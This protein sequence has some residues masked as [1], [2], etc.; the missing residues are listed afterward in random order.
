MIP[1]RIIA[2]VLV[3]GLSAFGA[4]TEVY[5][6]ERTD[7]LNGL[8]YGPAGPYERFAATAHFA[9]DPKAEA[10]RAIV[11]IDLAPRNAKGLVEFTADVVVFKPRD[12]TK[13]NGT[14]LLDIPN[15]GGITVLRTFGG[16]GG[17][18]FGDRFLLEQGYTV[19]VV[20]WQFDN[21]KGL[22]VYV[23]TARGENGPVRGLI[24]SQFIPPSRTTT[25]P[26]ADRSHT[27]Y[28][29]LDIND[30]AARLTVRNTPAARPSA[31]PR[32]AWKFADNGTATMAAGFEPGK[33]YELVYTA[34]DP[35]ISGLGFA[36]VRDFVSYLRYG[37]GSA[38][39]A[40]SD[41]RRFLKRSVAFGA[42]QSGRFLRTLMYHGFNADEKRRKVLDGVWAHVAGGGRGSF[43]VRFAQPSRDGH[44]LLNLFYPTD[45]FPFAD[46]PET[47]PE[48]GAT[49]GLLDRSLN[50]PAA[51][52]IFYTNGSYEY[53]G[54]AA[55]LTHTTAD[56][57]RDVPLAPDT[58]IYFLSGTQHG[59]GAKP[60]RNANI[61]NRANPV[62]Y[63]W[64][65]RALLTAFNAWITDGTAPPES[66]Y[67][68]I[69][70]NQLVA[71]EATP[72][73]RLPGVTYPASIYHAQRLEFGPE[74]A[75]RGIVSQEPPKMGKPFL[76]LVPRVSLEDGNEI[77]GVRQVDLRVPLATYTGWNL[78]TPAIG[79]PGMLYD[80]IGSFV[81]LAR[82]K[83]ERAKTGDPRPSLEDRYR[84][85]DD[86]MTK[87]A[88]AAADLVRERFLLAKDVP[89]VIAEAAER[90]DLVTQ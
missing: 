46:L 38:V 34:Q 5:V 4:V 69:D 14:I 30:P 15:R 55:S 61:Q 59:A 9:I 56:S 27:A 58:R 73:V 80:M 72:F 88:A 39:S 19:V 23:P 42:S 26:L 29:P 70:R 66:Q 18:E 81:P 63:R 32:R 89:R 76:N 6:Q 65:L 10:N 60:E 57:K 41:Q 35:P 13:G 86:Y 75:T 40:L 44:P 90:W 49:A 2:A 1:M 51:P 8:G 3:T 16:A 33:I 67:P 79:S 37:G 77:A 7:V 45:I 53:W 78:R 85:R 24:R 62:D 84:D 82:T 54:R 50:T 25:M 28:A 43:N 71:Y 36:A 47:D 17:D 68:R 87:V 11:D 48:T 20:G 83:T 12:P 52:K 21:P 31:I 64:T 74:F 22:K